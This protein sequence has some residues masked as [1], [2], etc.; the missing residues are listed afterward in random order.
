VDEGRRLTRRDAST[1]ARAALGAA[2]GLGLVG[3][4]CGAANP[5][6]KPPIGTTPPGEVLQAPSVDGGA[7]PDAAIAED[8]AAPVDGGVAV[9]GDGGCP[10]GRLEDPHRGFIRCL[11]RDEVDAGWLPPSP[12]GE[13][14][15]GGAVAVGPASPPVLEIGS[16]AFENGDVPK[17]EK[18]LQ[19]AQNEIAKCIADHGGL[20]GSAGKIKLQFLVRA[21]GKAEGVEIVSSKGIRDDAKEC[22]RRLLKNKNVGLPTAD[23]VGVN[24]TIV[25]KA[26]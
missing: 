13:P 9:E 22:I 5:E 18:F 8:G 25:L 21:R 20:S 4:A 15:D 2:L 17:A 23:P 3:M 24:V 16:P 26:K 1:W 10:Y 12:Q 11:N 14:A 19:N 7:L 6:A